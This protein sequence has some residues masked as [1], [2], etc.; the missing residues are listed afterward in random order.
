MRGLLLL[1]CLLV[2]AGTAQAQVVLAD[3]FS[4]NGLAARWQGDRA[5]FDVSGGYLNLY[6]AGAGTYYLAAPAALRDS[7]VWEG[8]I[9]C[10]LNPSAVNTGSVVLASDTADLSGGFT[11]WQLA[12][13]QSGTQ[14]GLN[15]YYVRPSG[16]ALVAGFLRGGL[17]VGPFVCRFRLSRNWDGRWRLWADTDGRGMAYLG[18][19]VSSFPL[20]GRYVGVQ[21]GCTSS[22]LH[23]Y[24]HWDDLRVTAGPPAVSPGRLLS[25]A[26]AGRRV[27]VTASAGLRPGPAATASAG[28]AALPLAFSRQTDGRYMAMAASP[29]SGLLNPDSSTGLELALAGWVDSLAREAPGQTFSCRCLPE[30]R[31]LQLT[32]LKAGAGGPGG[33]PALPEFIEVRNPAAH[34]VWLEGLTVT[35]AA[36]SPHPIASDSL[37]AGG[38]RVYAGASSMAALQAAGAGDVQPVSLPSLNDDGDNIR[39]RLPGGGDS[40]A[41]GPEFWARTDDIAAFSLERGPLCLPNQ[42]WYPSRAGLGAT[43]G[44]G[45]EYDWS[46]DTTLAPRLV[47]AEY[48]A[49]RGLALHLRPLPDSVA[50]LASASLSI[51]PPLATGSLAWQG[52]ILW[53]AGPQPDSAL[54]YRLTLQGVVGCGGASYPSA[55]SFNQ[56]VP[57]DSGRLVLNEL[58]Y[59]ALPGGLP[60]VEL[61]NPSDRWVRLGGLGLASLRD[62]WADTVWLPATTPPLEPGGY[63]WLAREARGVAQAYPKAVVAAYLPVK[64][65]TLEAGGTL[66][67][68]S[69]TGKRIDGLAYGPNLHSAGIDKT[70][71]VSLERVSPRLPAAADGNW[72]S[73]A[74]KPAATPGY[75]N[76]QS[77]LPGYNPEESLTA[78][79][80]AFSPNADGYQDLTALSAGGLPAGTVGRLTIF[81]PAGNLIR[82]LSP[83]SL[84]GPALLAVWDGRTD[85]GAAAGAGLYVVLA[86]FY[87]PSHTIAPRK[88]VVGVQP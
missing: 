43:P 20:S 15:L 47:A 38:Y 70:E 31:R 46:A 53:D 51:D 30:A 83:Q 59:D 41:Y 22:F 57:A 79:P 80:P 65:P 78:S 48:V 82:R 32:E 66:L 56:P 29:L 10:Q 6:A 86:E 76:S 49:G 39:L 34:A 25:A 74:A 58:L 44:R 1:L 77:L 72:Q 67:L 9:W 85:G 21:A 26:C 75:L 73:C 69:P 40:L 7:A 50:G 62:P 45:P 24:W 5:D 60:F 12:V 71:G 64:L 87:H 23:F 42:G 14:D 52:G 2:W 33:Q 17:A 36:L 16:R 88:A 19:A 28:A 81:D 55:L 84:T 37:A 18:E 61:H 8:S 11:G 68:L 63:R 13:G 3:S 54:T 27:Y 35:D 4:V